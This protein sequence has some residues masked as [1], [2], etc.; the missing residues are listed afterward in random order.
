[1]LARYNQSKTWLGLRLFASKIA[2]AER[3]T[4]VIPVY[5][6]SRQDKKDKSRAPISAKLLPLM[7]YVLTFWAVMME[8]RAGD[9][10][11]QHFSSA[12]LP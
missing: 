9:V 12:C 10:A 1:M 4:A 3:V 8:S 7:L 11:D 5:P 2:S 6:Y